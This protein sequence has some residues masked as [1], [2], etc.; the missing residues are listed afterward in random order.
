MTLKPPVPGLV[1]VDARAA[2]RLAKTWRELVALRS[3]ANWP[4]TPKQRKRL[5]GALKDLVSP[6]GRAPDAPQLAHL[7]ESW[8]RVRDR[9][10]LRRV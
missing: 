9:P 1:L 2:P 6:H 10:D 3:P 8:R 4:T 5:H 7:E